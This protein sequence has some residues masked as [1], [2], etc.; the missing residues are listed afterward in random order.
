[1]KADPIFIVVQALAALLR[2]QRMAPA[3][4]AAWLLASPANSRGDYTATVSPGAV[5]VN[6]YLGWGTS[7]CWWANVTGGYSNR[8]DYADHAFTQ[9][10]LNIVRYNIGGGE[11]PSLTGTVTYRTGMPGFEPTNG[12]WNWNADLN[13]RWMLQA[14]LAR[15]ANLVMAFANSPPWWMTVSGSVTGAMGGT[16]NLQVAYQGAFATYLATVVSN[17]TALD[18]VHF[19]YVTPMNEPSDA[20]TYDTSNQE[21]C[22]MTTGQQATVINDLRAALNISLPSAGIDAPSDYDE[23][24]SLNDINSYSSTTINNVALCTTHTYKAND[25]ASLAS[26]VSAI[27]KSLWVSEYGDNDGTG[28]TM[29]QRIHDDITGMGVRAWCYWQVVDSAGGWG[30][31]YNPLNTNSSGGVTTNYTINEKFYTMGQFSE[32]V[33]PGCQIISVNDSNTLAAYTASNSTLVLVAVN[34]NT[35]SFNVTYDL[36]TFGNIPWQVAVTQTAAGENMT[37]KPSPQIISNRMTSAI[38]AGSVTTFVLSSNAIAPTILAET[39]ATNGIHLYPGE[40]P[41]FA[42]TA[43]GS[44]PLYYK[45]LL[46]GT[47]IT[48]GTNASLTPSPAQLGN[49]TNVVCVVTNFTGLTA[50]VAW[51]MAFIPAPTAAYPRGVL[52]LNPIGYWR[53]NESPDNGSGN[54][55]TVCHDYAGG[56]NGVYSY[57]VLAQ[58]GYSQLVESAQNSVLFGTVLTNNSAVTQINCQDFTEPAGSNGEFSVM[59]WINGTGYQQTINSGIVTKGYFYGEELTLDEG[60]PGTCLRF[61]VRNAAG[62]AFNANSTINAYTNAGWHHM[63]GVCDEANGN[64]L[65]YVDG[66]LAG[67][68]A[69]P[70]NSGITNA[71][72]VPLAIGARAVN[73]TSGYNKQFLGWIDDVALYNYALSSNQ[74]QSI[75]QAGVSLPPVSLTLTNVDGSHLRCNWSYGTLQSATNAAGPYYDMPNLSQPY[76]VTISN[77]QQIFYRVREN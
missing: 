55:N 57:V 17:L 38:P 14:A 58:A 7:L 31:L 36:S 74:V 30:F 29:A 3:L 41:T 32:F 44:G 1:M 53:L 43:V 21:G 46:N 54:N 37:A 67:S 25:P 13:Q 68:A 59:A 4:V 33:R 9:L 49:L 56:N 18:G 65:L 11:N 51:S 66:A 15:G 61:S 35:N 76:T 10:R 73:A 77:G 5:L 62:T 22:H 60:A 16:N 23:Y 26:K 39:P 72:N 8:N 42:V 63:A 52:G 40:T 6:N 47:A 71:S 48:A 50:S 27:G 28:L 24:Q 19:D 20:W 70:A 75:Y 2:S 45:W 69:I 34:T 64:L 12:V